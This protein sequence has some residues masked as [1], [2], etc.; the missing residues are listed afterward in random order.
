MRY[1]LESTPELTMTFVPG[2]VSKTFFGGPE[3]KSCSRAGV[4]FLYVD[5]GC[6]MCYA[7]GQLL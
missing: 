7:E 5:F 4:R 2:I 3:K 1:E 6:F